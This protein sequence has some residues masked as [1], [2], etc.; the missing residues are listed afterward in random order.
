MNKGM[1]DMNDIYTDEH[2]EI[3]MQTI[4]E[5]IGPERFRELA[6]RLLGQS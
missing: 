5:R 4:L 1:L 2:W 3:L 6:E